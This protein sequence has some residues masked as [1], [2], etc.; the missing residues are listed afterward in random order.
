MTTTRTPAGPSAAGGTDPGPGNRGPGIAGVSVRL[1]AGRHV[2]TL[3]A[4][5]LNVLLGVFSGLPGAEP[6]GGRIVRALTWARTGDPARAG[7]G[8]M[9]TDRGTAAG[10]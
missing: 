3:A 5:W 10:R 1:T 4:A 6:D 7:Q 2:L 9:Q 8:A